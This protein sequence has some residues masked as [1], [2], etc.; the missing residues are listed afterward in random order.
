MNQEFVLV[1]TFVWNAHEQRWFTLPE[2]NRKV[3]PAPKRDD[4]F[5]LS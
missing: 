5:D 3:G 4:G 2:T 1:K